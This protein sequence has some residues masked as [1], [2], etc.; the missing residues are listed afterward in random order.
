[1]K[2]SKSMVFTLAVSDYIFL[3]YSGENKFLREKGRGG[4][5]YNLI[6]EHV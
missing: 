3:R 2:K 4:G 1:M 5:I 6:I